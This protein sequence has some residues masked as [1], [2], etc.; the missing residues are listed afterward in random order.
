MR[1][2]IPDNDGASSRKGGN[3]IPKFNIYALWTEYNLSTVSIRIYKRQ[4]YII[5]LLHVIAIKILHG[6]S[7]LKRVNTRT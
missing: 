2:L 5:L 4:A 7:I 6:W 3:R 1:P